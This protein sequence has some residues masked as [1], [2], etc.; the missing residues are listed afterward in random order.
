MRKLV[1]RTYSRNAIIACMLYM[2]FTL[3][4]A[5]CCFYGTRSWCVVAR[6]MHKVEHQVS[7]VPYI[8]VYYISSA[9]ARA[10][11]KTLEI[12]CVC[13]VR[14]ANMCGRR[15]IYFALHIYEYIFDGKNH[16]GVFFT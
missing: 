16:L 15:H 4:T 11:N 14:N 13:L 1:H 12:C 5:L 7:K 3:Y 10:S 8:I 6:A 2:H 9:T